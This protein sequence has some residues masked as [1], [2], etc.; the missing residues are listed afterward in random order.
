MY[1]RGFRRRRGD[2]HAR[3]HALLLP[4]GLL[5]QR[6]KY[7]GTGAPRKIQLRMEQKVP[8]VEQRWYL[9]T[10]A[11][12]DYTYTEVLGNAGM[13]GMGKSENLL[14]VVLHGAIARSMQVEG[15]MPVMVA[16]TPCSDWLSS[17]TQ[18]SHG[19]LVCVWR[20]TTCDRY[21][22]VS[23]AISAHLNGT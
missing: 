20:T 22:W 6:Q 3:T 2:T 18:S 11:S 21:N 16:L 14:S 1:P 15:G 5:A 10:Y 9:T 7:C 13:W 12:P 19:V 4:V 8:L 23:G 17:S